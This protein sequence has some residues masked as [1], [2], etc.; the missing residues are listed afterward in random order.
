M[1]F[2][3][4]IVGL[5]F[6]GIE[7]YRNSSARKK[8]DPNTVEGCDR[9]ITLLKNLINTEITPFVLSVVETITALFLATMFPIITTT[10][11]TILFVQMIFT[12]YLVSK[13]S[14]LLKDATEKQLIVV[15]KHRLKI[16]LEDIKKI[17]SEHGNE[18][19]DENFYTY[20]P[21]KRAAL[22][23]PLIDILEY[24]IFNMFPDDYPFTDIRGVFEK[25]PHL[26][27]S[28]IR[29]DGKVGNTHRLLEF[30]SAAHVL[31]AHLVRLK[32]PS[33][34]P[35]YGSKFED[36]IKWKDYI[37]G[38]QKKLKEEKMQNEMRLF[39]K[40]VDLTPPINAK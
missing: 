25:Y 27:W 16:Y 34:N 36:P 19:Y 22:I 6:I 30:E 37:Q 15:F 21:Q 2:C 14:N 26:K 3:L 40:E 23:N 13:N 39:I 18:I 4:P 32:L 29:S 1:Q 35:S 20:T 38:I 33:N 7:E 11:R 12:G 17:F 31:K 10:V 28:E 9:Q 5:P 24:Q 8:E